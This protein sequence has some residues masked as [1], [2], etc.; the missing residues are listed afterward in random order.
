MRKRAKLYV[1][2]TC[3]SVADTKTSR[4]DIA[5]NKN[6]A[7]HKSY[8]VTAGK[9]YNADFQSALCC[10]DLRMFDEII[11]MIL[12]GASAKKKRGL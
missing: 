3:E 5:I 6:L 2:S 12:L 9:N 1:C 4:A 11:A 10:R 7:D 8:P